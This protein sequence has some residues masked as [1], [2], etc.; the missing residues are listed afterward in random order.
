M[1]MPRFHSAAALERR[2]QRAR[3]RGY[4]RGRNERRSRSRDAGSRSPSPHPRGSRSAPIPPSRPPPR[5]WARDRG[6]GTRSGSR[7]T[8]GGLTPSPD[9]RGP[10]PGPPRTLQPPPPLDAAWEPA[11]R[12]VL[13]PPPPLECDWDLLRE[14]EATSQASLQPPPPLEEGPPRVSAPHPPSQPPP[15]EAF[16]PPTSVAG[17]RPPPRSKRSEY[18][19][20][21]LSGRA[22]KRSRRGWQSGAG[23]ALDPR[24]R[25]EVREAARSR[26]L[27][28][29][30][31]GVC[32]EP[33]FEPPD[34]RGRYQPALGLYKDFL[35]REVD[36]FEVVD[37]T[38]GVFSVNIR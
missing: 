28:E 7:G 25:P 32:R 8:R 14:L 22:A 9:S 24:V 38:E 3:D 4:V 10:L 26:A 12:C 36:H 21:R 18:A 34:W 17:S 1:T 15:M 2:R 5:P 30:S 19:G 27:V 31:E 29:V 35:L 23:A 16:L 6:R 20:Q 33:Y 13:Q 11:P 37:E